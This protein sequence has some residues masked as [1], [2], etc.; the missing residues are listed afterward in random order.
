MKLRIFKIK[1][2]I[3][4]IV[5]LLCSFSSVHAYSYK[6]S[7]DTSEIKINLDLLDSVDPF[8][9][10]FLL[11]EGQFDQRTSLQQVE[12]NL[13]YQTYLSTIEA[14]TLYQKIRQD[15]GWPTINFD[16]ALNLGD[17]SDEIVKLRRRLSITGDMEQNLGIPDVFDIFVKD[18]IKNFQFRHGLELSGELNPETVDAMNMSVDYRLSQLGRSKTR[19]LNYLTGVREEYI[20]VN[21]PSN[22]L[23]IISGGNVINEFKVIVGK[24]D[25]QTPSINSNIYEVNFF[26]YWHIPKS[27][28]EKDIKKAMLQDPDY[29]KKNDI[30]MYPDYRYKTPINP[31]YINWES[32]E[33]SIYNFRQNPGSANSM[34][35]A[36]INFANSHAIYLHD[37]P[38]KILFNEEIRA[39]SS[40]CIRVQNID[41]LI[42]WLLSKNQDWNNK[43]LIN[44]IEAE[45]TISVKLK[46]SMQIKLI[47]LTAWQE[48]KKIHF[49][50]DI[51]GKDIINES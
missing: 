41:D 22:Q 11:D 42:N 32:D 5:L 4:C 49:R 2:S 27:I 44:I 48:N 23:S 50:K 43:E 31:N 21:I 34:G 28:V 33:P 10:S 15:G 19:V 12:L 47:Y 1:L 37:T 45:E 14:I 8:E 36:K 30:Y 24:E 39:Y 18:G 6:N 16:K 35:I 17:K 46:E 29:L 51:Y 9:E 13:N 25:R 26:P 3:P 38:N 40:G 20:L 7:Y